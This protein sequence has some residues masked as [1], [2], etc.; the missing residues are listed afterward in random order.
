MIESRSQPLPSFHSLPILGG[1]SL[2]HLLNDSIQAVIPAMFPILETELKL[3]YSQLGLIAFANN[4]V[5]SF[6]QPLIGF[7]TDKRPMPYLLPF[8]MICS[9]LGMLWLGV[10]SNIVQL[11]LAV[12][13]LGVGSSVFHPEGS[14]LVILASGERRG[15]GQSLFQVSGQAGQALAPIW[16][17]VIFAP[18]GQKGSWLFVV[19]GSI[20]T[21]MLFY[22]AGWY[23]TNLRETNFVRPIAL[24][25]LH[26]KRQELIYYVFVLIAIITL[27]RSCYMV[28]VIGFY[29]FFQTKVLM[30]SLA[31]AQSYIFIFLVSLALGTLHGGTLADRMGLRAVLWLSVS[32]SGLTAVLL[33]FTEGWMAYLVLFVSGYAAMAGFPVSLIYCLE[34]LPERVGLISGMM[35]GLAFGIGALAAIGLGAIGDWLGIKNMMIICCSLPLLGLIAFL[36]PMERSRRHR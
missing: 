26:T 27:A 11:V 20:A 5:A 32:I 29:T 16:T 3:S 19:V 10:A 35:F 15:M 18:L 24:K 1:I 25:K 33:P 12:M 4:I 23:K 30:N 28:G 21:I 7:Y 8:G 2:V 14:R 9:M 36:L 13:L 31:E 34:L 17:I 6:L 22:L